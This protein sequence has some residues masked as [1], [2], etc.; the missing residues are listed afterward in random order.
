ML[1]CWG[2]RLIMARAMLSAPLGFSALVLLRATVEKMF[3][4]CRWWW[5]AL[6]LLGLQCV[7]DGNFVTVQSCRACR[8]S[9]LAVCRVLNAIVGLGVSV[10]W[11]LMV[12][13][14]RLVMTLAVVILVPVRFMLC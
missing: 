4:C 9:P 12:S 14:L 7:F 10:T 1:M 6:T 5:I 8:W 2:P 11:S 13:A 3:E